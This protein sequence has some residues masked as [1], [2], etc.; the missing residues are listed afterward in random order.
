MTNTYTHTHAYLGNTIVH[1]DEIY[2]PCSQCAC[3]MAW[4]K[5]DV[6]PFLISKHDTDRR[7]LANLLSR[8]LRYM[9]IVSTVCVHVMLLMV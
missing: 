8:G 6:V 2:F 5:W 1:P 4:Q 7:A 3:D 9:S